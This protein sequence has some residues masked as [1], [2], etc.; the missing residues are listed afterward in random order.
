MFSA[1]ELLVRSPSFPIGG[2]GEGD[3]KHTEMWHL[4]TATR[5]L[6]GIYKLE[7][8]RNTPPVPLSYCSQHRAEMP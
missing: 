2:A 3:N 4:G 1:P 8:N 5:F 7:S 6:L